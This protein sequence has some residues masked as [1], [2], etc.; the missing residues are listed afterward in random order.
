[1]QTKCPILSTRTGAITAVVI[2]LAIL[3]VSFCQFTVLIPGISGQLFDNSKTTSLFNHSLIVY[4]S[5]LFN[6]AE[7]WKSGIFRNAMTASLLKAGAAILPPFFFIGFFQ[8]PDGLLEQKHIQHNRS[9]LGRGPPA[10][11]IWEL[12][13][14]YSGTYSGAYSGAKDN[15]KIPIDGYEKIVYNEKGRVGTV[16]PIRRSFTYLQWF[17]ESWELMGLTDDDLII[18]ENILLANPEKGDIVKGTG[19]ARKIR[20][21]VDKNRGKSKGGRVICIPEKPPV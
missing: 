1:M 7:V 6:F 16:E 4:R 8:G 17:D 5:L 9:L 14:S 3:I 15:S 19:G 18:L 11:L 2:C 20:I 10:A 21:Q 13:I 12:C